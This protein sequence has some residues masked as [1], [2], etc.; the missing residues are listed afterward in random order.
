MCTGTI[1]DPVANARVT[2]VL[3]PH[4]RPSTQPVPRTPTVSERTESRAAPGERAGSHGCS[5]N[6]A[7]TLG[8]LNS[9]EECHSLRRMC[10]TV[11]LCLDVKLTMCCHIL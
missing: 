2:T 9:S 3:L 1:A 8:I 4:G 5:V 11:F 7:D 6:T 10:L